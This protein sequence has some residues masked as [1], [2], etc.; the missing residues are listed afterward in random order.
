MKQRRKKT[1]RTTV[2]ESDDSDDNE[3][4]DEEN[5]PLQS[6]DLLLINEHAV[7]KKNDVATE[8]E[9]VATLRPAAAVVDEARPSISVTSSKD[10]SKTEKERGDQESSKPV[11]KTKPRKKVEFV[12]ELPLMHQQL[13]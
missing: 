8:S 4:F 3:E 12:I 10:E 6:N 5:V 13:N 2:D 7:A 9:A 1:K 11:H